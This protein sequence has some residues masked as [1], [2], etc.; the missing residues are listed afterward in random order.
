MDKPSIEIAKEAINELTYHMV[1]GFKVFPLEGT[2]IKF[3][4]PK[5]GGYRTSKFGQ[6]KLLCLDDLTEEQI[7]ELIVMIPHY[8]FEFI[9]PSH[10]EFSKYQDIVN[11]FQQYIDYYYPPEERLEDVIGI[12]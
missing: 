4:R 6:I 10:T 1:S 8:S 2:P 7:D 9:T 3:Y 11:N 5:E 12:D